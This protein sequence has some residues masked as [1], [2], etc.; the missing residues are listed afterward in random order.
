MKFKGAT[1]EELKRQPMVKISVF[2]SYFLNVHFVDT[3][4]DAILVFREAYISR[5]DF[6]SRFPKALEATP[7]ITNICQIDQARIPIIKF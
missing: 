4:I 6:F 7:G 2:G 1:E 3:D 5:Q